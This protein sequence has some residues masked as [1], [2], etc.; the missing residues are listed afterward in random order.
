MSVEK[1]TT[2]LEVKADKAG[3]KRKDW[4]IPLKKRLGQSWNL[5]SSGPDRY[6]DISFKGAR[7]DGEAN[8]SGRNFEEATDFTNA[9]FYSPP[10]FDAVTNASQ[11]DFT[12]AHIGFALPG[13][14]VHWTSDTKIPLRLRALRK[15][16]E[17]TKNHD[18]ERDLYIEERK[19]ERGVYLGQILELDEPKKNLVVR[20]NQFE[21]IW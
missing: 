6:L 4:Q 19:A 13:R 18:L 1:W 2:N 3:Q 10:K 5:Y 21:R 9:H 17:E 7:F 12:G 15:I 14:I 16:A 11:I 8:F 20:F